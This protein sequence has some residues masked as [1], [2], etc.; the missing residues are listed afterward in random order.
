MNQQVRVWVPLDQE[1][2]ALK[3]HQV[4]SSTLRP[5]KSGN[6]TSELISIKTLL[7]Q[8]SMGKVA[9]QQMGSSRKG[10]VPFHL[11]LR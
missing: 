11:T 9:E 5:N 2:L 3:G 6:I 4:L 10:K 1:L 7:S 8:D